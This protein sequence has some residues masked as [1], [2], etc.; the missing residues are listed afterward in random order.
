M[1]SFPPVVFNFSDGKTTD[2]S[3]EEAAARL[4]K[5]GTKFGSTLIFNAH[6][7]TLNVEPFRFPSTEDGLPDEFAKMLFRISSPFPE[8]FLE[9]DF[10]KGY[11]PGARGFVFNGHAGDLLELL[12]I[13]TRPAFD[14]ADL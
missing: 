12:D 13:G 5:L 14:L 6:I 8:A 2:G 9:T 3:P 7:S 10:G 1:E 4:S 11:P